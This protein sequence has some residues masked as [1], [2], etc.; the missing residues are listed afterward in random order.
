MLNTQRLHSIDTARG[1]ALIAMILYHASWNL[2]A[3]GFVSWGVYTDPLWLWSARLIAGAFLVL[4]GI[5]LALAEAQKKSFKDHMHR[6]AI[7]ATAALA[8]STAT[9]VLFGPNFVYFGILHHI[10]LASLLLLHLL[11]RSAWLLAALALLLILVWHAIAFEMFNT[12]WLAWIGLST[13]P[14]AANDYVPMLPWLSVVITGLLYGRF[15]QGTSF[16]ITRISNRFTA[17]RRVLQW[18]GRRSLA[19]YLIHQ[20]ILF[21]ATYGAVWLING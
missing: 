8:V 7:V 9:Y 5:S 20:P 11:N 13:A 19:I 21:G 17:V 18:M 16:P 3:F 4:V 14:P 2:E 1:L 15:L 10:A 12:R 6:I